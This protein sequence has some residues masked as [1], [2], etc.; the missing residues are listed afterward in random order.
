ML[1]SFLSKLQVL[2]TTTFLERDSSET[3]DI[4]KNTLFY[5]TSSMATSD[6]FRFQPCN[7]IKKE[8]PA[9]TFF[10]EIC[11]ISKN[12]FWQNTSGSLHLK[13]ICELWEAFQNISFVEHLWETA[14]FM[15]KLQ[16]FKQQIQWKTISQ[17][18]FKHFIQERE[19]LLYLK[20]LK[21]ICEEVNLQWSCEMPIWKFT[22]K[23][24]LHI[25]LHIIYFASIF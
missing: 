21:I 16:Y 24:P 1:E 10:C 14:Y 12:S 19:G 13:F 18:L 15:Y 7:F 6:S 9:K 25:L 3:C 20:C 8:I 2:T 23:T 5:W 4:F 17:M 22:R 11:T